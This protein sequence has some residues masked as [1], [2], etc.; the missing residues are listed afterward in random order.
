MR[1]VGSSLVRALTTGSKEDYNTPPPHL[2]TRLDTPFLTPRGV[3][4]CGR[5]EQVAH[6][7]VRDF[8]PTVPC[9]PSV[10][11]WGAVGLLRA[12]KEGKSGGRTRANGCQRRMC[13]SR[14]RPIECVTGRCAQQLQRTCPAFQQS[15]LEGAVG[16][17]EPHAKDI[18]VDR[19]HTAFLRGARASGAVVKTNAEVTALEFNAA[20]ETWKVSPE[21]YSK[22]PSAAKRMAWTVH[23]VDVSLFSFRWKQRRV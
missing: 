10:L 9:A 11:L 19:I 22:H 18:D 6:V 2:P 21:E 14:A 1:G 12:A 16:L 5:A 15:Y 3:V 23:V 17:L 4:L 7:E 8:L 20:T 13:V